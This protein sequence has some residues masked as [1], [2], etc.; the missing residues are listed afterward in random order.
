MIDE[1]CEPHL[2]CAHVSCTKATA[3]VVPCKHQWPEL[4][5]RIVA[6]CTGSDYIAYVMRITL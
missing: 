3:K 4:K 5:L 2:V 6:V 1:N